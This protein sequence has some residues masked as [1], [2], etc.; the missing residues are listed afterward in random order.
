VLQA[1]IERRALAHHRILNPLVAGRSRPPVGWTA[2]VQT[3]VVRTIGGQGRDGYDGE[4][5][6]TVDETFS[7]LEHGPGIGFGT[8]EANAR[9]PLPPAA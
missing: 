9:E 3:P 1:Q 8:R 7:K 6:L 4:K 2:A 5:P